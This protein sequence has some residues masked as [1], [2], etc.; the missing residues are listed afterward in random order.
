MARSLVGTRRIITKAY[1][2]DSQV[3]HGMKHGHLRVDKRVMKRRGIRRQYHCACDCGR[4][5]YLLAEDILRRDRLHSGC[6]EVGCNVGP[7]TVRVWYDPEFA[8]WVQWSEL[9]ARYSKDVDN[10]WGGTL[11]EGIPQV[12]PEDGFK[13]FLSDVGPMVDREDRKW[14]LHKVTAKAPYSGINVYLEKS[15][16]DKV[17]PTKQL[18]IRYGTDPL[19]IGELADLFGLSKV[20]VEKLR[21]QHAGGEEL[22]CAVI[23]AVD[24]R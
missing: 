9:L 23:A 3:F 5:V 18:H 13:Q 20:A 2:C 24:N 12:G 11:Y 1:H 17:F 8:L 22:I 14:W 19:K 16:S 21:S 7:M 10:S 15:P 6:M 4:G